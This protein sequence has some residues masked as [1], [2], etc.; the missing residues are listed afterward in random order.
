MS[1]FLLRI[2]QKAVKINKALI[3]MI[4]CNFSLLTSD[5]NL[6]NRY[7][8][9]QH[10]SLCWYSSQIKRKNYKFPEIKAEDIEV[11]FV[12]GSGP[13]GQAVAKT[14][15]K[16]VIKHIPTGIIVYCH[17]TRSQE[18]NKKGAMRLL[19]EE[20]DLKANGDESFVKQMEKNKQTRDSETKRKNKKRLAL[21]K[22]FK[23]REGLD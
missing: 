9:I 6:I 14:N 21:K 5:N 22:A 8:N 15:N 20:L 1:V 11:Q 19:E 12:R 17:K 7:T 16:V 2:S 18:E 23:E 13:G 4:R 10:E 3:C